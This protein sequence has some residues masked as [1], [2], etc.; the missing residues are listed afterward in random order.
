MCP[1]SILKYIKH[2]PAWPKSRECSANLIKRCTQ[3]QGLPWWLSSKES[4]CNAGDRDSI[5]GSGRSPGGG[6]GNPLQYSCLENSIDR[7]A[8]WATVHGVT[9]SQTWLKQLSRQVL[10]HRC[11]EY[12]LCPQGW[13]WFSPSNLQVSIQRQQSAFMDTRGPVIALSFASTLHLPMGRSKRERKGS[14]SKGACISSALSYQKGKAFPKG[15]S[16]SP[17]TQLTVQ[18]TQ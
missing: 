10:S 18:H 9:K 11:S 13:D 1:L 14:T 4:V 12:Q 15:T 17:L 2:P 5:P 7:G 3:S 8:W 6:H 16:K